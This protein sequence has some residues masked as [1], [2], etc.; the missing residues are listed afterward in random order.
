MTFT[1]PFP[2]EAPL[3]SDGLLKKSNVYTINTVQHAGTDR[4][5]SACQ[6]RTAS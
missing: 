1:L 4:H 6:T 2:E 3:L 5:P